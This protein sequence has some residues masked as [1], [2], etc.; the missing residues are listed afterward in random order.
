MRKCFLIL[1]A[2]VPFLL[3][4]GCTREQDVADQAG[5]VVTIQANLPEEPLSKAGFNVPDSGDGL[6][7]AWKAGDC[8]RVISGTLKS[9]TYGIYD[10]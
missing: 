2:A 8:I 9:F 4:P 6:H 5:P 10:S 3:L 7:L 1:A